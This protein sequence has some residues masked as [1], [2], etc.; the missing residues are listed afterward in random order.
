MST[1][2]DDDMDFGGDDDGDDFLT[3]K[4]A[5]LGIDEDLELS[6]GEEED[7][8]PAPATDP[9]AD[10]SNKPPGVVAPS[11]QQAPA[12]RAAA[13]PAASQSTAPAPADDWGA[14]PSEGCSSGDAGI[15]EEVDSWA[16]TRKA[17][18]TAK[19][20]PA[21]GGGPGT[22]VLEDGE[23]VQMIDQP[24]RA[25]RG[26]EQRSA[27]DSGRGGGRRGGG[28]GGGRGKRGRPKNDGKARGRN[29]T[30]KEC[31]EWVCERLGEPKYYLMCQVVSTIGYN[32][33]RDLLEAVQ[34]T[35]ETGGMPTA[36][37]S[38]KRT[39]GGVFFTLL[40]K[41]MEPARLKELYADELRV[42][43]EK[44]RARRAA[45]KR[46]AEAALAGED[47]MT[48]RN[49]PRSRGRGG[50]GGGGDSG[51]ATRAGRDMGKWTGPTA[52][53]GGK[54]GCG[55]AV[56]AKRARAGISSFSKE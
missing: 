8:N 18:P 14:P 9:A 44:E 23:L 49:P 22:A 35:Q 56:A 52:G 3:G 50:G 15:W 6:G 33:T 29:V 46:K 21:A 25:S 47:V 7:D 40:K 41:H 36:D 17:A 34:E 5:A 43:K 19:A 48:P 2:D 12:S 11:P 37:G 31:A 13:V 30:I 51:G 55:D 4:L 10:S 1:F 27:W 20:P 38:R 24:L 28:G 39:A 54:D 32:K 26:R 16:E 53:A 42:K 45:N